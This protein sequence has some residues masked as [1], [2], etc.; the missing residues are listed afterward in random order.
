MYFGL[1]DAAR[2]SQWLSPWTIVKGV[3]VVKFCNAASY[4][5]V[6]YVSRR[7]KK[8]D[9]V[10]ILLSLFMRSEH[11][12]LASLSFLNMPM[13]GVKYYEAK[14]PRVQRRG[15]RAPDGLEGSVSLLMPMSEALF[16]DVNRLELFEIVKELQ[17][18]AVG[19]YLAFR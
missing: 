14:V 2:R 4:P 9:D 7:S 12:L 15:V 16:L 8:D 10:A 6:A 19:S 17:F 1:T 13:T 5:A 11:I 18:G 3:E